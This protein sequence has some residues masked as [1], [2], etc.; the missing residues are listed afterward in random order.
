MFSHDK[1]NVYQKALESVARLAQHCALWDKRH[2]VADHLL[3]ASESIVLNIA[4]GARLRSGGS[5]QHV[6]DYAMGSALECSACLDIAVTKQFLLPDLARGEKH[7]LCEVVKMLMGLRSSWEK[8]QLREEPA[9]YKS[10]PAPGAKD[11]LFPHERLDAYQV[12]LECM[13]WFQG[14]PAG[15]ELSSRLYR[16]V[17]KAVT[18]VVLNIAEGN[19]RYPEGD[20]RRFLD[21]AQSSAVKAAAYLDLCERNAEL[22][23]AQRQRGTGLLGRIALMAG[24]MSRR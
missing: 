24:V 12:G 18:S 1:L 9:E 20:R 8:E 17:D 13:R 23:T 6:L 7:S 21:I 19:G 4:E 14:L 2:S 3:R 15:A 11:C 22:E 16:Q 10:Q 5:K